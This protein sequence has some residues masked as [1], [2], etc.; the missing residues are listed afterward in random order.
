MASERSDL[1]SPE[2]SFV[3]GSGCSKRPP[4]L[5]PPELDP[6]PLPLLELEPDPPLLL[7]PLPELAPPLLLAP[8][9]PAPP[10]LLA[11]LPLALPPELAPLLLAPL[12]ELAP[13]LLAPPL[14]LAP[15]LPELAPLLPL[16]PPLLLAPLP[17]LVPLP[18]PL[19][20]LP[21]FSV[22]EPLAHDSVSSAAPTE[23]IRALMRCSVATRSEHAHPNVGVPAM[24]HR[25]TKAPLVLRSPVPSERNAHAGQRE[26]SSWPQ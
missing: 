2:T 24:L 7:A 14:P 13:L 11:L 8:L 16:V 20:P 12:P 26:H 23:R 19:P 3:Q 17:E 25:P 10:L 4:L 9:L 21:A 15:L 6:A 18:E 1:A 22:E 5:P